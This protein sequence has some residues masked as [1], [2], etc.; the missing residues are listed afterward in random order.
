V[1]VIRS[2]LFN[3]LF[4]VNLILFLVLGSP[5][6][7]TPRIWS[8]RAL[9]VWARSSLWLLRVVAGI[10]MELRGREH[11]PHGPALIA[12]KHQSF[13]ETFAILPWLDDPAMVLKKE[14]VY[15]PWFGWFAYKFRMIAVERS[16]GSAALRNLVRQ[17]EA[18][19]G[20]GRQVV[21]MPEGTRRA[22]DDPPA[23]KPGAAA[24]YATLGVPCVP[25]ALNSGLFWPRR[26][27][28]RYPGTIVLEF[29]PP[30]P[31][32]LPRKAFQTALE[33]AIEPATQA[34]VAEGRAMYK[35]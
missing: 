10:G 9:Q 4:Y 33:G 14:L 20:A 24:L 13:W 35:Q 25:F 23:Y 30:I 21:I 12:G 8:I 26:K 1:T 3:V 7:F 5:F 22:P 29:L 6:F 11:I 28:L 32:G 16:A 34:L 15:I 18:C 17:A 27:F 31:P 19:I 2:L